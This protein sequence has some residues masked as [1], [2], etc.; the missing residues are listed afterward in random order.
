MVIWPMPENALADHKI[1]VNSRAQKSHYM[2]C[3]TAK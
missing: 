2:T 3:T 1:A